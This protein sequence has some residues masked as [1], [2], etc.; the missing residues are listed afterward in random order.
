VNTFYPEFMYDVDSRFCP[1]CLSLSIILGGST[2]DLQ[3]IDVDA[4]DGELDES[5]RE[6]RRKRHE[7][8]KNR[9]SRR[10]ASRERSSKS[11]RS[12][13]DEKP[14]RR[15]ESD[16]DEQSYLYEEEERRRDEK[17]DEK[18]RRSPLREVAD[19]E[20]IFHDCFAAFDVATDKHAIV[21]LFT[22]KKV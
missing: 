17:R 13:R 5:D 19:N 2:P 12:H 4:S 21:I 6:S 14:S 11:K 16:D 9:H 7:K 8:K 15:D 20:G 3:P 1:S 18:P 10:S 22:I